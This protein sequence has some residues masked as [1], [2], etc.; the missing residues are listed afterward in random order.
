M[1]F[2]SKTK[3]HLGQNED[4][5]NLNEEDGVQTV[6]HHWSHTQV[7]GLHTNDGHRK[8][9]VEEFLSGENDAGAKTAL[10]AVLGIK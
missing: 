3:G 8:Y 2:H 5:W 4:W 10:K 1:Q 9:S 6:S 7:N